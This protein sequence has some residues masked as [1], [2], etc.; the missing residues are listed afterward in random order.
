MNGWL[1][2]MI[3]LTC[4]WVLAAGSLLYLDYRD[5]SEEYDSNLSLPAPPKGFVLDNKGESLFYLWQP[6]DLLAEGKEAYT[7]KFAPNWFNIKIILVVPMLII[8][9]L[10]GSI[11]WVMAGFA[12]NKS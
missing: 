1:R 6:L 8:W 2:I 5:F 3:F 10:F 9:L 12:K 11:V 7:R 4:W